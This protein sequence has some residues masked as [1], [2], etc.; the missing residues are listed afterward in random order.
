MAGIGR[1]QDGIVARYI[2]LNNQSDLLIS[3]INPL[4]PAPPVISYMIAG[5]SLPD[6]HRPVLWVFS[7]LIRQSVK[8]PELERKGL[9]LGVEGR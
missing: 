3:V 9:G 1:F 7:M 5:R 4:S 2:V 6:V 8:M